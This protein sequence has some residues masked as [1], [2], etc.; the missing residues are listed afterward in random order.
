M[1]WTAVIAG[2][3]LILV[4]AVFL[5]ELNQDEGWYL[6]GSRLASEGKTPYADFAYTQGPVMVRAY[7]LA[8]PLIRGAGVLGGRILSAFFAVA[9]FL[10]TALLA[11]RLAPPGGK[12]LCA[13]LALALTGIN[14]YQCYFCSV[15]KTYS[16]TV[17]LISGGL[18]TLGFAGRKH[19]NLAVLASGFLLGLAAGA[20]LTAGAVLPV[21]FVWLLV[22]GFGLGFPRVGYGGAGRGSCFYFLIGAVAAFG[23]SFGPVLF[24]DAGNVIFCL[25]RYHAGREVSGGLSSLLLKCGSVSRL[26]GAYSAV[27]V[28][29]ILGAGGGLLRKPSIGPCE[30][31]A[32]ES[33]DRRFSSGLTLVILISA[34]LMALAHIAA[35]FP[36]DDYQ[37]IVFPLV[38]VVV[39]VM[40]VRLGVELAERSRVVMAA[41]IALVSA[42]MAVSSP[43]A[44]GWLVLGKDRLWVLRREEAPLRKL[45]MTGKMLQELAPAGSEILTQDIYLAVET[46]FSVPHGFEMGQF[47]Y[48]PDMSDREARRRNVVNRKM[49]RDILY[50]TDAPVAAFSGYGLAVACPGITELPREEQEDLRGIVAE[51]YRL[52]EEIQNFGQAD[53]TL[54]IFELR[55]ED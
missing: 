23:L 47:S 45:Q 8:M 17:M 34:F 7:A 16:L 27:F 5:G 52:V 48:F 30:S 50:G 14:V 20:R 55:R 11:A 2:S 3:L 38:V 29:L 42:G 31:G 35:P 46:G 22:S 21:V 39:S 19:G 6:Y 37:V 9:G 53:T 18:L 44:Q 28:L 10:F 49:L 12:K 40:L 41:A 26:I 4:S 15:V 51:R 43:V 33:E 24:E 25:A 1:L 54:R 36:Y 13:L 32:D